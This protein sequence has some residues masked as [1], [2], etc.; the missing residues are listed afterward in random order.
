MRAESWCD[1]L[2][3]MRQGACDSFAE[4]YTSGLARRRKG[5][6]GEIK[7]RESMN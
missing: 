3:V 4:E 6:R 1:I 5:R 7:V 2:H